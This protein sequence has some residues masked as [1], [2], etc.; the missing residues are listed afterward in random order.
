MA[1]DIGKVFD[2]IKRDDSTAFCLRCGEEFA[3]EAGKAA[4]LG[5]AHP[6]CGGAVLLAGDLLLFV[7]MAAMG[8]EEQ[9]AVIVGNIMGDRIKAAGVD[10]SATKETILNAQPP[11]K[12]AALAAKFA[13]AENL[14]AQ[15]RKMD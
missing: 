4:Q 1:R 7:T 10:T 2:A 3:G 11:D 6:G 5:I 9:A 8:M 12:R 13:E 14:N 15:N